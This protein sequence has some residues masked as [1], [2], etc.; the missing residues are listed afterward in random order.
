MKNICALESEKSHLA[1]NQGA[2][3]ID[4]VVAL[5]IFKINFSLKLM[6]GISYL[7]LLLRPCQVFLNQDAYA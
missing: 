7:L 3:S 5:H 2:K 1:R 4:L 6:M